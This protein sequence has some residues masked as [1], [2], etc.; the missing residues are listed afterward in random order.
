MRSDLRQYWFPFLI[1]ACC[2]A[3]IPKTNAAESLHE[4]AAYR[5][6]VDLTV[7]P[8]SRLVVTANELSDSLSLVDLA[9]KTVL[10]ELPL[11]GSPFSIDCNRDGLIVV[12][13][14]DVGQVCV[15]RHTDNKLELGGVIQVGYE[16]L[17]IC[18]SGN[19]AYVGLMATGEV[20]VIDAVN[21]K[22]T[23]KIP[24]GRWPRYCAVTSDGKRLAVG[25]SGDSEIAVVDLSKQAVLYSEPISG[26]INIGHLVIGE[27]SQVYFPWMVYRSNPITV[28]NIR[29]GWV[30]ASRVARI[31]T[32]GP[33][34]REA[35]ALD[36]PG[37]AVADPVGI[38]LSSAGD[39]IAVT[40]SG[41]HELLLY[42]KDRMPFVGA[43]GPGD[44]IDRRLQFDREGFTRIDLGGRPMGLEYREDGLILIANHTRDSIQV[45]SASQRSLESEISLGSV[46]ADAQAKQVHYGM[47]IFFDA[48]RSLDQWYS[49][50]SCHL[51]GRTNAKPM[52]TWNDGSELTPKSV[53]PLY[54]VTKTG[55]WTWHGW[56]DNLRESLQNSFVSTM[57]GEEVGSEEIEALMAYLGTLAPPES[58]FR[59]EGTGTASA[60]RGGKLFRSD[61]FGCAECHSGPNFTDGLKH[62]VGLVREK[63]YYKGYNT[64]S[65][66][67]VYHKTRFL[68]DGRAKTLE[69]V[70]TK[71][72]RPDEIGGGAEPTDEELQDLI[73]Y[74]KSL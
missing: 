38:G 68:H 24:V 25:L 50:H 14:R 1:V 3:S 28:G 47:E 61:A 12:S 4:Q 8:G 31:P 63:D 34:Y 30:L 22:V 55:P 37:E 56:Q 15:V 19:E 29:R 33:K 54:N 72:H 73:A 41:T 42:R 67:G 26:G 23:A 49:C 7:L 45:V 36:V 32:T 43:G 70:L 10:H 59:R 6:P 16:P 60:E 35:I 57:Q 9:S 74:L 65:L 64:P 40:S 62:D 13:C 53:L 5:G 20:A 18:L 51:D 46:P 44:L 17:G 21:L 66:R 71:Y 27:D 48:E 52:D 58:P 2:L 11:P 39:Q 69:R